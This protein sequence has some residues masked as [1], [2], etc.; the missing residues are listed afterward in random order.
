MTPAQLAEIERL[1][2]RPWVLN[3]YFP[4]DTEILC[5]DADDKFVARLPAKLAHVI[6]AAVNAY[7][8]EE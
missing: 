4:A 6:V 1:H 3:F 5:R 8:P 2:P 7:K